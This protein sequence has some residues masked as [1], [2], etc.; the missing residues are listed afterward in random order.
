MHDTG[1]G[2]KAYRREVVSGQNVPRG[3]QRFIPA[4]FGVSGHQVTEVE[5][6]DRPR[7]H[8]Q[9]HYG[10]SRTFAVLRDLSAV[11]FINRA[12]RF[13]GKV[14][15]VVCG[16][17]LALFVVGLTLPL[18]SPTREVLCAAGAL[19]ALVSCMAAW[20]IRRYNRAQVEKV[21]RIRAVHRQEAA[22]A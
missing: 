14:M 16:A 19:L 18:A 6:E 22:N 15:P 7:A 10:L 21:Y 12:P 3:F 20:G 2:L 9:T 13:Y 5:T 8:G 17:G 11:R 1:C 4:V